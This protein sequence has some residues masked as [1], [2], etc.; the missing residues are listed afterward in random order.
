[1]NGPVPGDPRHTFPCPGPDRGKF[2]S[3][4]ASGFYHVRAT[5]GA[6]VPIMHAS[7]CVDQIHKTPIFQI[8]GCVGL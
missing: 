1:M 2:Y 6:G 8:Y 4:D 5:V 7:A 3:R